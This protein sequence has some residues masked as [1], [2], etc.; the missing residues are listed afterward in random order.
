LQRLLLLALLTHDVVLLCSPC[1]AL[2]LG[3]CPLLNFQLL[4]P[5]GA[6]GLLALHQLLL[7]LLL[8]HRFALL[9]LLALLSL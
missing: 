6:F 8:L 2:G 3:R 1:L 5:F 7:L 4:Y 9:A